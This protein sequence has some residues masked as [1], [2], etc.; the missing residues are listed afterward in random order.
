MSGQDIWRQF[1][2]SRIKSRQ[3]KSSLDRSNQVKL[4]LV[5]SDPRFCLT[6]NFWIQDLFGPKMFTELKHFWT[7]HFFGLKIFFDPKCTWEWSL[8]LALAQLVELFCLMLAWIQ[9]AWFYLRYNVIS[10][11]GRSEQPTEDAPFTAN[12]VIIAGFITDGP[13]IKQHDKLKIGDWLRTIDGQQV[14]ANT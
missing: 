9:H 4:E 12:R 5:K 6:Q 10:M 13:A 2:S 14:G 7:Q 1:G 11:S 8:T 3:V